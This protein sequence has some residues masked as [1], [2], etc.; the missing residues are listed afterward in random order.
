MNILKL[1]FLFIA[2]WF[3]IINVTR[4]VLKNSL[5]AG[6]LFWHAVGIVGFVYLQFMM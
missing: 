6:N 2:V 5:S 4:L 3:T 1:L